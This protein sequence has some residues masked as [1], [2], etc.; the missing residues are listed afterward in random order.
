MI[1]PSTAQ[2]RARATSPTGG[3]KE[4]AACTRR[5]GRRVVLCVGMCG[6]RSR[7]SPLP[8]PALDRSRRPLTRPCIAPCPRPR[9]GAMAPDH[10]LLPHVRPPAARRR[11]DPFDTLAI[12]NRGLAWHSAAPALGTDTAPRVTVMEGVSWWLGAVMSEIA[13]QPRGYANVPMND[14]SHGNGCHINTLHI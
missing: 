13:H 9:H 3:R 10:G 14:S 7:G 6:D 8:A 2:R 12:T 5:R 4:P 11:R 1:R